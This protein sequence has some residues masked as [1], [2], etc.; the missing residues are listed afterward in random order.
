MRKISKK[1]CV[2]VETKMNLKNMMLLI[3]EMFRCSNCVPDSALPS[4]L[5]LLELEPVLHA[6]VP[7]LLTPLRHQTL[8]Q[9]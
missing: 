2:F 5:G 1:K 6:R 3:V 9:W 8:E 7:L 4:L